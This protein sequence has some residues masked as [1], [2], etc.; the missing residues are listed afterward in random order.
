MFQQIASAA[1]GI[2]NN[3]NTQEFNGQLLNSSIGKL[4]D[5]T[6]IDQG[7]S[8]Y[9]TTLTSIGN[10]TMDKPLASL[11]WN[12]LQGSV[13]EIKTSALD[14]TVKT[15]TLKSTTS[16]SD[17]DKAFDGYVDISVV[18]GKAYFT[19]VD[20]YYLTGT[21]ST[22]EELCRTLKLHGSLTTSSGPHTATMDT[23]IGEVTKSTERALGLAVYDVVEGIDTSVAYIDITGDMTFAEANEALGDSGTLSIDENG[24]PFIVT[25]CI[26][27]DS[28]GKKS[29]GSSLG[30]RISKTMF[31]FIKNGGSLNKVIESIICDE[32]NKQ[33]QGITGYL[34]GNIYNRE[35]VDCDAVVSAFIPFVFYKEQEALDNQIMILTKN[36]ELKHKK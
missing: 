26:V 3:A 22:I 36:N 4:F 14:E 28:N 20:G 17:I 16:L 31:E 34:S 18:D 9:R 27:E 15:F 24:L 8:G 1:G 23:T 30:I 19:P 29:T 11:G 13:I 21:N 10:L 35:F 7:S 33:K 32:N 5:A 2:N 6:I 25:Y 12:E